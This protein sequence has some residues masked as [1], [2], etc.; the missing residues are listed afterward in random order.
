[1]PQWFDG[2]IKGW[3]KEVVRVDGERE[4]SHGVLV[5]SKGEAFDGRDLALR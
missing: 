1:V 4:V 5:V 2:R 3:W